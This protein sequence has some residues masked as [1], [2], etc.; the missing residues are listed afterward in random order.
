MK[1][2]SFNEEGKRCGCLCRVCSSTFPSKCDCN[3][4]TFLTPFKKNIWEI[5]IF[6]TIISVISRLDLTVL[7]SH[8]SSREQSPEKVC[9][10]FSSLIIVISTRGWS[11]S[12]NVGAQSK[13]AMFSLIQI[14][15]FF[16]FFKTLQNCAKVSLETQTQK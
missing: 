5:L 8:P 7:L 9:G 16:F 15:F 10:D 6:H 11:L 2:R 12:R 1:S 3:P 14:F 13:T 4:V